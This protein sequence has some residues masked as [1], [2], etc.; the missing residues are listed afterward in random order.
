MSYHTLLVAVQKHFPETKL[1]L[2]LR[3]NVEGEVAAIVGGITNMVLEF[4]QLDGMAGGM[5]MRTWLDTAVDA[6][7]KVPKAG[8]DGRR[9]EAVARG[10]VRGV[11]H[12][13]DTTLMSR[14]FVTRIQLISS[15]KSGALAAVLCFLNKRSNVEVLYLFIPTSQL[16]SV[17][18]GKRG[19]K[20]G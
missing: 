4:S 18:R 2:E 11:N 19:G 9:Q 5:A 12:N 20:T 3:G 14:E 15:L 1:G 8:D 13:V 16:T 10:I 7:K 17:W 6:F